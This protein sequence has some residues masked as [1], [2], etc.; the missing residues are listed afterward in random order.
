MFRPAAAS[1]LAAMILL[2]GCAT[3]LDSTQQQVLV[4]TVQDHR[5]IA[6]V[7]CVLSNDAGRWFVTT[8]ARVTVRKSVG[9]MRVD[10]RKDGAGWAD[11]K[12]ESRLNGALWGNIVLTA[13]VGYVV[14]RHTGAGYDYPFVLTVVMQPAEQV[15][16]R[17][18]APAGATVY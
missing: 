1:A 14:D 9:Q 2:P 11:E 18:P 10:C 13:G 4:Q 5:E 16:E 17:L 6:G 8:P 15:P 7:G 12:V 3:I